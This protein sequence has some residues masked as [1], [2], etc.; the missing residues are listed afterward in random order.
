LYIHNIFVVRYTTH[1]K[2]TTSLDSLK[3][4]VPLS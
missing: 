3:I 4:Q 1:V 2:N